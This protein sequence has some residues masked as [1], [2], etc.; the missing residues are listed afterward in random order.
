VADT[1]ERRR[2]SDAELMPDKPGDVAD[3]LAPVQAQPQTQPPQPQ[4]PPARPQPAPR[5]AAGRDEAPLVIVTR[6]T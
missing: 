5:A 3:R 1:L 4:S 6:T 2:E